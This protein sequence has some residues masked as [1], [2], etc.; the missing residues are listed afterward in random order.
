MPGVAGNLLQQSMRARTAG[1]LVA[2]LASAGACGGDV[3][4]RPKAPPESVSSGGAGSLDATSTTV[5][6][7]NVVST[8]GASATDTI[9]D[10]PGPIPSGGFGPEPTAQELENLHPDCH[11]EVDPGP[12]T[13]FVTRYAYVFATPRGCY[14]FQYGG[15]EGNSNNFESYLDCEHHCYGPFCYCT[16]NAPADCEVDPNCSDCQTMSGNEAHGEPCRMLGL[17][18]NLDGAWCECILDESGNL[19]WSCDAWV[20]G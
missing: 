8:G 7:G 16:A 10:G 6:A 4:T 19:T 11:A 2:L 18:C 12:C 1:L 15:C 14:S 20:G 17:G 13:N 9:L 5:D 3:S